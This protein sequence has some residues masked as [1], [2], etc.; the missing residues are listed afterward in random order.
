MDKTIARCLILG[1]TT[2]GVAGFKEKGTLD[3]VPFNIGGDEEDRTP[4][5]G[6]ANAALS[7]LSYIPVMLVSRFPEFLVPEFEE[8]GMKILS[9]GASFFNHVMV[10][11]L[12]CRQVATCWIRSHR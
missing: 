12:R 4:G 2:V 5:L 1:F 9:F 3:R 7:Q 10:W 8:A 11:G 6:I